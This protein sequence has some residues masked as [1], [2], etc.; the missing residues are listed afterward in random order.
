M[1]KFKDND[2]D[3][4][5]WIKQNPEGYVVNSYRKPKKS[6][7]RLHC[8]DCWTI[9]TPAR[10]NWTT[11]DYIKTCSV[12]LAELENWAKEEIGGGMMHC[13]ICRPLSTKGRRHNKE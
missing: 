12:S 2:E 4:L 7:L 1:L 6:F 3:Y 13:K 9:N 10:D 11:K 8:A 5:R